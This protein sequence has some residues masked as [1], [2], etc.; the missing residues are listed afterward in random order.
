MSFKKI[1]NITGWI[2][3]AIATITYLLSVERTTSFWDCGEFIIT[4]YKLEVAHSPGAP[5]YMMLGRVFGI[6]ASPENAAFM[7]NSM[8][9]FASG[10]TVLFLF[11]TITH[12]ARKIITKED[13]DAITTPDV[14]NIM[15]AGVI[16]ALAYAFSDTFWF[17]AVEAEV[18]ATSSF[19]TAMTFW[20]IL[21]WEHI[22]KS[23]PR[24]DRWLVLIFFLVG[25]SI[26]VH[27]LNLLT[28][29]SIILV[30][31]LRKTEK[32]T[33]L[34]GFIAF[35]IGGIILGFIQIGVIQWVSILASKF[36]VVF[37]NSF[38][39]PFNSGTIIFLILMAA[40][41]AFVIYYAHKKGKQMLYLGTFCFA[42]T[43]LGFAAPY[44]STIIRSKAD[45]PIDMVNPDNVV[46]LI[47]YLQRE[48]YGQQ[49]LLSGGNYDA[50]YMR[51][52]NG[53]SKPIYAALK[54]DGKDK[55]EVVGDKPDVI[56]T[57]ITL[58]PRMWDKNKQRYY[59]NYLGK[60][61]NEPITSGE[62]LSFFF[63]YQFNWMY[64]RYFMWNYSGRQNDYQGQGDPKSANWITGIKP[65]DKMLGR[66]DIDLAS[67]SY[68]NNRARNHYYMLPFLLG[69]IGL[70]FHY[71]KRKGDTMVVLS[72]FIMT[73]LAI[74]VYLNN[75]PMQPRE[76]D[77]AYI[78]TYA[79]AVWIGL[80]AMQVKEW[81]SRFTKGNTAPI[82]A[83]VICLLL[84]PI[85]MLSQNWDDHNRAP[86][87][88]ARDHAYNMLMTCDSNAIL[89]V[90]GDNDTYPLWYL[91]EIE[92]VRPD[93][94]ILNQNLLNTDWQVQQ[95]FYKVNDA[96]A[97]PMIWKTEDVV[98]SRLEYIPT[99]EDPRLAGRF[100]TAEEVINFIVDPK[101]QQ[102]GNSGAMLSY[103]PTKKLFVPVD[104]NVVRASGILNGVDNPQILP[105]L[106]VNFGNM[107]Q[108]AELTIL[109]MVTAIA[110][111]GWKRPIYF[112]QQTP[113]G[114]FEPYLQKVGVLSKLVPVA[115]VMN[116][117]AGA[118]NFTGVEQNMKMFT[119]LYTLGNAHTDKPYYDDKAKN[120][121]IQYRVGA[122]DFAN[123]LTVNNRKADAIK[124]L[125]HMMASMSQ[126]SYPNIVHLYDN[127]I[128][129]IIQAYYRA[130]G[131]T[132]A[133]KYGDMMINSGVK[134][135][136]YYMSLSPSG[137]ASLENM[138][139]L[140]LQAMMLSARNA[141]V[142]GDT[143]TSARWMNIFTEAS[144]K[145][146]LSGAF[147]QQQQPRPAAPAPSPGM[148]QAPN[149]K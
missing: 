137:R 56:E 96:D 47:P 136:D 57:P 108:R 92:G 19:F 25:L 1:N 91:Q 71:K 109:N 100:N 113:A 34:G 87:T 36:E 28:I 126:S 70:I 62:N 12:F 131:L 143:A 15:G 124:V 95:M 66:G 118:E 33:L 82:L 49:P 103:M 65:I 78:S 144:A 111:D 141:Q 26:G 42:F 127:S 77:Y 64:W 27:L 122:A 18:Y 117:Q 31:Y 74:V 40:A 63:N 93:V 89:I 139:L 115:P 135:S 106:E 130:G 85:L 83:T 58:F 105:H 61:Q 14:L 55:Y 146:G 4:A 132:Q 37:T 6:L 142:A 22:A 86:K 2:V 79:F 11:W 67:D 149:P 68:A 90:N 45:V 72:L 24:A 98:G 110:K 29:P 10:F 101:N 41:I 50:K 134:D 48:Q 23:D 129:L 116:A 88:L 123:Y 53:K 17:S 133:A 69:I 30:Y 97:V 46:A 102:R 138:Q 35:I 94:R 120:T 54:V 80:G 9:A 51:S 128:M 52:P 140:T 39:M 84:V 44:A 75:S 81:M 38:G 7:I 112:G 104:S 147:Q 32:P 73:G 60:A 16:G 76:R 8:S 125:D 148:L 145:T 5:L 13:F 107:V 43:L 59:E 121:L 114:G 20:A 3:F 99:A 21:R 119:E